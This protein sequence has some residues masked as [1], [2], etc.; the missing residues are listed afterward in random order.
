MI[1]VLLAVDRL[2]FK[3]ETAACKVG[4]IRTDEVPVNGE[5]RGIGME[6]GPFQASK[7]AIS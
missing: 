6:R 1:A 2:T 7:P 5:D 3:T 4:R